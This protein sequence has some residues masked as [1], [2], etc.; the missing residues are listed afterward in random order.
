MSLELTEDYRKLFQGCNA[1]FKRAVEAGYIVP[2]GEWGGL[3]NHFM[4]ELWC[5]NFQL[6][7]NIVVR[8]RPSLFKPIIE[9]GNP[10][11]HKWIVGGKLLWISADPVG[12]TSW[13]PSDPP[14]FK[15]FEGEMGNW[16]EPHWVDGIEGVLE[17]ASSMRSVDDMPA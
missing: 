9:D 11:D 8:E 2:D 15:I 7:L 3:S 5:K 14:T 13:K 6:L 12:L 1:S 4:I 17:F 10:C 16:G